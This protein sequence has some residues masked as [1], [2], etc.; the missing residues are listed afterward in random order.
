MSG[1]GVWGL[2]S[3]MGLGGTEWTSR[4]GAERPIADN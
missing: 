4:M 3:E 1:P 2:T